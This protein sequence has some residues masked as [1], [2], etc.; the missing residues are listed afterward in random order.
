MGLATTGEGPEAGE[1]GR[2]GDQT[3]LKLS[4]RD[5]GRPGMP[6]V[7]HQLYL[8]VL[9][10]QEGEGRCRQGDHFEHNVLHISLLFAEQPEET[11]DELE[12][13]RLGKKPSG[14]LAASVP[15]NHRLRKQPR[16]RK[17][18]QHLNRTMEVVLCD[19]LDT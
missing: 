11:V 9:L 14:V 10:L 16:F 15:E 12:S 17:S 1:R 18:L 19:L 3:L 13:L 5:R 4:E 6:A 2:E 7:E 8:W